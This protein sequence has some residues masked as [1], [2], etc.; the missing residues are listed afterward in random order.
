[1]VINPKMNVIG[2]LELELAYYNIARKSLHHMNSL[3][4]YI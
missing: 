1:M 3:N 4:V 2:W